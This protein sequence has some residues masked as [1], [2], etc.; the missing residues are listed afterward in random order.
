MWTA[1]EAAD[2]GAGVY[3]PAESG[4][5]VEVLFGD[6]GAAG[7]GAVDLAGS[8]PGE[9]FSLAMGRNVEARA[10]VPVITS[11]LG[12]LDGDGI[13]DLAVL[14]SGA[15]DRAAF[16]TILFGAH[17]LPGQSLTL[18]ALDGRNGATIFPADLAPGRY[19]DIV[20][21][22]GDIDGDGFDDA[23]FYDGVLF[24]RR[25]WL[26]RAQGRR[27]SCRRRRGRRRPGEGSPSRLRARAFWRMT[28]ARRSASQTPHP[29]S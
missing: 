28:P 25:R 4:F 8:G 19:L 16:R 6:T 18:D 12:D 21:G 7:W 29:I 9:R 3:R 15:S 14:R 23:Q 27:L 22:L 2:I 13:D 1:T 11:G 20:A 10:G 26:D 17:N 5:N 24:R